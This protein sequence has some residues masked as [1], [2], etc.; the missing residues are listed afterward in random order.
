MLRQKLTES[1]VTNARIWLD[2]RR[3]EKADQFDDV[4][5][6]NLRKAELMVVVL[7]NNW[8]QRAYCRK[9]L[10]AFV[11]LRKESGVP[12]VRERI[13]VVGKDHVDPSKRPPVLQGQEGYLFYAHEDQDDITASTAFF[14]RGKVRTR[15]YERYYDARDSLADSLHKRIARIAERAGP[16]PPIAERAGPIRPIAPP[17]GRTVYLAKPA[18]DM[19]DGYEY[20]ADELQGR[21]YNVVPDRTADLPSDTSALAKINEA[22]SAAEVSVHL[23]GDNYGFAPE[24]LD[25][26]VKLQLAQ[27]R[28]K[29]IK[30]ADRDKPVFRR[31]IWA[32]KVLAPGDA[33]AGPSA[34]RDPIQALERCDVQTATDK[35]LGDIRSNFADFLL[36]YLAGTARR[37]TAR[38]TSVDGKFQLYLDYDMADE[39]YAVRVAEALHD[40]PV[41]FLYPAADDDARARRYNDDQMAKCDAVTVFWGKALEAWARSEAD[42]LKEAA[43]GK[44]RS[45]VAGPPKAPHKTADWL[46]RLF[47]DGTFDK[48]ID[49][50]DK[51]APTPDL[52]ADLAPDG[53]DT[54]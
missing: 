19:K 43:E 36:Q 14:N 33:S 13:I 22:L 27:A 40:R 23:V 37:P 28:E 53:E 26:I 39:S 1:G 41:K 6:E 5:D 17:N 29:A 30:A 4:I 10:D 15:Y 2:R 47:P 38:R 21:G 42:K 3:I 44:R 34:E 50:V 9:E 12:N 7:S 25:P 8:M 35:V 48:V 32:P 11:K 45:L 24:G 52:L 20:L 46:P 51:D 16:S 18:S 49:L 31:I 54:K